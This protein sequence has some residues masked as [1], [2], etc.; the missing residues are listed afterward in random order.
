MAMPL[1][2]YIA[3]FLEQ[4]D[5]RRIYFFTVSTSTKQFLFLFLDISS[6]IQSNYFDFPSSY[7]FRTVTF[8]KEQF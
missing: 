1:L 3:T 2:A 8:L 4:L 7:L 5:F 6:K